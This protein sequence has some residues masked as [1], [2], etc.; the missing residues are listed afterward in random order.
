MVILWTPSA[1]AHLGVFNGPIPLVTERLHGGVAQ[2]H[3]KYSI[4]DFLFALA[5]V[6]R[7]GIML[8][9]LLTLLVGLAV[10]ILLGAAVAG[11]WERLRADS[12]VKKIEQDDTER[13][14]E[15]SPPLVPEKPETAPGESRARKARTKKSRTAKHKV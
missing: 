8:F 10:V 4:T 9:P 3:L 5:K 12:E 13:F 7:I 2:H 11:I 1:I 6:I 15:R 14:D